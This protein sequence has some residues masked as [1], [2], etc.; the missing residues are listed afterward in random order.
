ML[1]AQSHRRFVKSHL[2]FDA[3]PVYDNMR[4]IHVARDGRDAC[5]S[6]HNH[7]NGFTEGSLARFDEIGLNDE[8]IAAPFPRPKKDRREF[9]REWMR[10]GDDTAHCNRF[11]ETENSYWNERGRENLLLVHYNDLKADL[12]GEMRRMAAFLDISIDDAVWPSLVDAARFETMKAQGNAL[13][14]GIERAFEGGHQTF[15]YRGT[16]ERWREVL[17]DE[18]V[19]E[20]EARAEAALPPGLKAWLAGGRL[21]TG[22]PKAVTD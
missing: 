22:D 15:L 20:Y 16:N 17:T 7:F 5:M 12:D 21:K 6:L 3:V 19:A 1:E 2:P 13:L 14:P 8:T 10:H 9:W 11:F 4:Y 18:D